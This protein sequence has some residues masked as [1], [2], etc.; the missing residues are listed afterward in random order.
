VVRR[1]CLTG[2]LLGLN[3]SAVTLSNELWDLGVRDAASLAKVIR[4]QKRV[5]PLTFGTVLELSS[6]NYNLRKWLK[7]GGLTPGLEVRTAVIPSDLMF[8]TFRSGHL[9]GYCVAEP[10]NSAAVFEG[11]GSVVATTSEIEPRH[12]EKVL[13]VLQEFA[14]QRETEHLGMIAALIEASQ[15]CDDPA[16]RDELAGMLAQPQ[17][18]DVSKGLLTNA[19]VGPFNTGHGR[20]AI[21]DFIIYDAFKAGIPDRARGKWVFDMVRALGGGA[22]PALRNDIIPKVFREDIFHQAARLCAPASVAHHS[23][24]LPPS[25]LAPE[26]RGEARPPQCVRRPAP[27]PQVLQRRMAEGYPTGPHAAEHSNLRGIFPTVRG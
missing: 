9:D 7:A 19:L 23:H 4:E 10:W 11:T 12:P 24:L 13:L 5:R 27:L 21:P 15:F 25:A 6:Q 18:F 26:P 8:D 20:R 1:S 2:L 22:S 14:E 16:N 17:Y 3:G